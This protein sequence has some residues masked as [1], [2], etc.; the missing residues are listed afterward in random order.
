M[1]G[2]PAHVADME[3][4]AGPFLLELASLLGVEGL[5]N[6]LASLDV[7]AGVFVHDGAGLGLSLR[8][9]CTGA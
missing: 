9:L 4:W 2:T 5:T 8:L 6:M 3:V 1:P 7:P